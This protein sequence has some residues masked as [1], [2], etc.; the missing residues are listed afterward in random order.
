MAALRLIKKGAAGGAPPSGF[1]RRR[2][3]PLRCGAAQKYSKLPKKTASGSVSYKWGAWRRPLIP[4][5]FFAI[6]S[7]DEMSAE[8]IYRLNQLR[9]AS[10][11][12]FAIF[13]SE[14][15]M[16]ALASIRMRA[17]KQVCRRLCGGHHPDRDHAGLP[18]FLTET[19]I[20]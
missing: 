1:H 15:G 4:A 3:Y 19:P 11:T 10:E 2:A 9:D 5:G 17:S 12:Q 16:D 8:E 7:S 18:A 14:L 13:K 6:A 20:R